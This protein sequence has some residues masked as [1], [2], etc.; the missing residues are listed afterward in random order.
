MVDEQFQQGINSLIILGA[1]TFWKHR[2][3]CVF[4]VIA[5]NMY[6]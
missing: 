4:D 2:N 5:D 3:Q 1:W 6:C